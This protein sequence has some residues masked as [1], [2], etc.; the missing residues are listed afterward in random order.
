MTASISFAANLLI[1]FFVSMG[2]VLGGSL[3]G[4]LGALVFHNPPLS[5]MLRLSEELKIWAM[6]ATLGG[7]MDTLKVLESG[8]LNRELVP[9]GK[10]ITYLGVAFIGCQIGALLIR[11]LASDSEI[12][13]LP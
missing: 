5:V 4:G 2:M 12:S 1:D 13:W 9:V 3:L 11:W 8:F 7:T 10:Q 6:V